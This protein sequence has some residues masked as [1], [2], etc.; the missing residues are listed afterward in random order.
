[1]M[2]NNK[3]FN[4]KDSFFV[5]HF[6]HQQLKSNPGFSPDTPGEAP[7]RRP[8]RIYLHKQVIAKTCT[9]ATPVNVSKLKTKYFNNSL[10]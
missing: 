8:A 10:F 2:F 6:C 3:E 4:F 5:F 9:E 1:M 7:G